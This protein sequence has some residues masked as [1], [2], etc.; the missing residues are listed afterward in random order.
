M[1]RFPACVLLFVLAFA[2]SARAQN[3][4][5]ADTPAITIAPDRPLSVEEAIAL[6]LQKSFNLR[7]QALS[8]ENTRENVV[9]QQAAYDPTFT[10]GLTRS[11]TQAASTTNRLDGTALQGPRNDNT[12]ARFG[13]TLPRITATNGVVAINANVSRAGTNSTNSLLNPSYGNSVSATLTQPLLRDF[14]RQAAMAAIQQAQLSLALANISY[15]SAVITT[16]AD[17]ENAYYSLV[18]A[19]QALRIRELTLEGARRLF[20]ETSARR[21]S[22]V[23]TDLDVLSAEVQVEN[24]RRAVVQQEQTVRNAEERLLN[25]INVP[26]FDARPG[27]V[28]F[29]AYRDGAP[30]FAQSYKLAREFYPDTLSAE[31]LIKQAELNLDTARR[32]TKPDLNLQAT[33]GY[34]ARPTDVSYVETISNLPHDH[35]NNWSLNLNYSLPWG[36]RADQARYRQAS[37]SLTA[38]KIR[39]EQIE[40]QLVVSVRTA[41]RAVETNRVA[42]DIAAKATELAARQ[43]DQ[44]KARYDAGLST[45]RVLLQFQDDLENARFNELSAQL[46]LR[47]AVAELRRLE[48]TSLQRFKI[49][50]PK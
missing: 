11:L 29:D 10:A 33:L 14:G 5:A 20:E 19:R 26:T 35:G 42:T 21:S 37:N 40:Q 6:A 22:G 49:D 15:K 4:A 17:T 1:S 38:Q 16:I 7:I 18:A 2:I 8:V 43:Y 31:Q 27:P 41:V 46:A 32:N 39:L 47:Q 48:G 34:T 45:S 24:G 12:N 3:Q 9:I 13:V 30:N 50:L 28:A 44:Q 25:L 23:A 36:R